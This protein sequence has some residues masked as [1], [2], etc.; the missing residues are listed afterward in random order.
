LHDNRLQEIHSYD[1]AK[2]D[3]NILAQ[4]RVLMEIDVISVCCA[5]PALFWAAAGARC[6]QRIL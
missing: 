6:L 1:D 2:I 5:V 4:A 3:T